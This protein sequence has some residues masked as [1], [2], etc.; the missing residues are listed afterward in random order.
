MKTAVRKED[1]IPIMYVTAKPLMGPV[2]KIAKMAPVKNE[3][4]LASTIAE[5]APLKPSLIALR[6]FFPAF[7]SSRIRS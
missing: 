5:I 3:V 1:T 2:P 6:M 7:I 4:T